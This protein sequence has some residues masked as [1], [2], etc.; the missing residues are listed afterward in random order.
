MINQEYKQLKEESLINLKGSSIIE[1]YILSLT[2]PFTILLHY[3]VFKEKKY[4]NN[5]K[6]II[7]NVLCHLFPFIITFTFWTNNYPFFFSLIFLFLI[8]YIFLNSKRFK[9]LTEERLKDLNQKKKFF[10]STYRIS[11]MLGVCITIL[12]VDF[13][14][15]FDRRLSKCESY[16][17]SMMDLGV[18]T[19]IFSSAMISTI[20]SRN[21]TKILKSV[22]PMIILGILR[23]LSITVTNYPIH[24]TEYGTHWNFFFTLASISI[25]INLIGHSK[26][27]LYLGIL[28]GV[29]HEILLR[30]GLENYIM[31]PN[32]ISFVDHNK[33]GICTL[34]SY[35]SIYYIASSFGKLFLKERSREEW[36]NLLIGLWILTILFLIPTLFWEKYFL[37]SRRL[38]N[39]GYILAIVGQNLILV[40]LNLT[41]SMFTEVHDNLM[42]N[43]VNS[44]PLIFFLIANCFTGIINLTFDT[45]TIEPP[46]VFLILSGYAFAMTFTRLLTL[47][48]TKSETKKKE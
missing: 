26:N 4:E 37:F 21:I 11:K 32:R 36:K 22:G 46:F 20:T 12:V 13:P 35:I 27:D 41:I 25:L 45:L 38:G 34:L 29:L 1:S 39:F 15:S 17:I 23:W 3:I 43:I 2:M 40:T 31:N 42:V 14:K 6:N 7:L 16:G 10:I 44:N 30:N 24:M 8:F 19:F 48:L 5:L 28:A 9:F 18:G 47:K 33:E